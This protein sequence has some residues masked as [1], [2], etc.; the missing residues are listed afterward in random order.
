[1]FFFAILGLVMGARTRRR[2]SHRNG[3]TALEFLGA[4]PGSLSGV[5]LGPSPRFRRYRT[6]RLLRRLHDRLQEAHD[7]E[8]AVEREGETGMQNLMRQMLDQVT[9]YKRAGIAQAKKYG[10]KGTKLKQELAGMFDRYTTSPFFKQ[11]VPFKPS[12]KPY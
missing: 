9:P 3:E 11:G 4:D 2:R 1:M 8:S 6:T 7:I 5:R 10:D 12:K